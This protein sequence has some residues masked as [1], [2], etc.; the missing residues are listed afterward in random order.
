MV[1]N[2]IMA[3]RVEIQK[4]ENKKRISQLGRAKYGWENL[5]PVFWKTY[6]DLFKKHDLR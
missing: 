1:S 5:A 4:Q 6:E 2:K 3:K